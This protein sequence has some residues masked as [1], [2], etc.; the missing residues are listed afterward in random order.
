MNT[1]ELYQ[2]FL[3]SSGIS[4]DTRSIKPGQLFLALKG[5]NFNGNTYADQALNNGAAYAVVDEAEFARSDKH[6]LVS[7]GLQALQEL[8]QHHRKQLAI[9]IIGITGSNGKT[10]TKELCHAVLSKKYNT[11]ATKGNLNNHIGVPLSLLSIS[12]K[13]EIAIIEMGAN[14]VGEIADLCSISQ[15]NYGLITNVGTAHI[16]GFGS[17]E[18]IY[19][20]K[21]ELYDWIRNSNEKGVFVNQDID[22]LVEMSSGIRQ[23][24]YGETA[25][26]F[27]GKLKKGQANLALTIQNGEDSL[28]VN[29]QLIGD[30]NY[31][32]ALVAGCI[33]HFFNVPLASIKDA[34]EAYTP[35][36]NRSQYLEK[37]GNAF[38]MDAYNAN[39]S[40]INAALD[41]FENLVHSHK[42]VILGDMLELGAIAQKEHQA[43]V[44]RVS[45]IE[46]DK[47]IFVG[48]EFHPFIEAPNLHFPDVHALKAWWTEQSVK[49][50]LILIKG[51]RG[52]KLENLVTF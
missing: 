19:K 4:T 37:E 45:K 12:N 46:L 34:L 51:S 14:H 20:A 6:I 48:P 29:S 8:A 15:P 21:G 32:N 52:I 10:T 44:E 40:S 18:N 26:F 38:I 31:P 1:A 16:E 42:M 3:S 41:H 5:G 17:Q 35:S 36:N 28:E 24:L 27:A 11:F 39:P 33:G 22:Y 49:D 25:T 7:D 43:I 23:I 13:H 9:P 47:A 50:Y 2:I 30:Y